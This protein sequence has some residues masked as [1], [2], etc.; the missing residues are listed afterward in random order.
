[1]VNKHE[2]WNYSARLRFCIDIDLTFFGW[3]YQSSMKRLFH[4][5][6]SV[7]ESFDLS[8]RSSSYIIALVSHKLE[9]STGLSDFNK[10]EKAASD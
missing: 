1:M 9:Q 6:K 5:G 3:D 10:M 2:S 8:Q 4:Q 7:V